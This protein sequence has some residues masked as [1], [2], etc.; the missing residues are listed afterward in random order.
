MVS[1]EHTTSDH[2]GQSPK[3]PPF[4]TDPEPWPEPVSGSKLLDDLRSLFTRYLV[5][6]RGG[7]EAAALW[8]VF[9][10]AHDAFSI[11]PIL[12]V[13]A[14]QKGSGKTTLLTVLGAVVRRPLSV[15]NIS[16]AGVFRVTHRYGATLLIDEADTFLDVGEG[17]LRGVLNSGHQRH[18]AQTVRMRRRQGDYEPEVFSTWAPKAIAMI[19]DLPATLADRAVSIRMLRAKASEHVK[20]LRLD[21]LTELEPFRRR[22]STWAANNLETLKNHDPILP[23]GLVNRPADN[24]RPLLGIADIA[25]GD[26]PGLARGAAVQLTRELRSRDL[27]EQV[28]LLS[29]L[30]SLFHSTGKTRLTSREIVD[31]L[32]RRDDRPWSEWHYGKPMTQAQLARLLSPFE[33]RPKMLAAGQRGYELRVC[34]DIFERYLPPLE[35]QQPQEDRRGEDSDHHGARKVPQPIAPRGPSGKSGVSENLADLAL[36]S[37]GSNPMGPVHLHHDLATSGEAA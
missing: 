18:G 34:E 28:I 3:R 6:P 10:H 7:A 31:S 11:S 33:I 2:G 8:T 29:D 30:R 15:S 32:A 24:W 14:P 9:T 19:G 21:R 20:H 13:T 5:L 26:W 22:A 25:G 4:E 23:D 16:S 35:L 27:S 1:S 37:G 17:S 12:G 36:P